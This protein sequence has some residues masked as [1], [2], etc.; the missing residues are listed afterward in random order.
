MPP[1]A[2]NPATMLAMLTLF[3]PAALCVAEAVA[4]ELTDDG[5]CDVD[6]DVDVDVDANVNADI[7]VN[8]VDEEVV[9]MDEFAD[10]VGEITGITE[11]TPDDDGDEATLE[12]LEIAEDARDETPDGS[13]DVVVVESDTV[14]RVPDVDVGT[15]EEVNVAAETVD[16]TREDPVERGVGVPEEG[17]GPGVTVKV[18]VKVKVP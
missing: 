3:E 12:A 18:K 14:V 2:A 7:D 15:G 10:V 11:E 4:S 6:V 8:N 17:G 1:T 13:T 5:G 16:V 9:L